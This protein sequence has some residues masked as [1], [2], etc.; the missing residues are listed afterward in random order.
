MTLEGRAG[1]RRSRIS[2][3]RARGSVFFS[4]AE[5]HKLHLPLLSLAALRR[6]YETPTAYL[7]IRHNLLCLSLPLCLNFSPSPLCSST[8]SLALCLLP[9]LSFA[10]SPLICSP[11]PFVFSPCPSLSPS[12]L[13]LF[14]SVCPF[15]YYSVARRDRQEAGLLFCLS[16]RA[17]VTRNT[18]AHSRGQ[19]RAT[20]GE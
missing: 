2:H 18:S 9:S 20:E 7:F 17:T 11:I 16:Y 10:L 1:E 19:S 3:L 12:S 6:R 8:I 4:E 14:F 15:A 13:Q 5:L